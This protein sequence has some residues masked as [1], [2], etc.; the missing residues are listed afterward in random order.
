MI[1]KR[2]TVA[3]PAALALAEAIEAFVS[4]MRRL[5]EMVFR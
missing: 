3:S 5:V 4:M 1:T 2:D